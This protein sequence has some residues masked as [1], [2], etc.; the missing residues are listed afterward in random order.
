M[1]VSWLE[2]SIGKAAG[3]FTYKVKLF[4]SIGVLPGVVHI[5]DRSGYVL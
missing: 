4:E 2:Q 5:I 1:T 3:E